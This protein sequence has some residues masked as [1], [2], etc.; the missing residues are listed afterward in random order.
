MSLR[1]SV[2]NIPPNL[3]LDQFEQPFKELN[4]FKQAIYIYNNL[5]QPI[6]GIV[7]FTSLESADY[8]KKIL[9]NFKY[10]NS[11]SGILIDFTREEPTLNPQNIYQPQPI[12]RQ[13]LLQPQQ[14]AIRP[15]MI[16][17]GQPPNPLQQPANVQNS[18]LLVNNNPYMRGPVIPGQNPNNPNLNFSLP[19]QAQR[20][21]PQPL[22]IDSGAMMGLYSNF[23]NPGFAPQQIKESSKK[24]FEI[25]PDATNC[26]YV[27]GVPID[28]SEREVSR[29]KFF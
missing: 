29:M 18:Q 15:Q 1:L 8:A 14:G 11:T 4:G 27:D 7:E 5:N 13:Q 28:S 24:I 2:F 17:T 21:G 23:L 16:Q 3:N 25:P 19:A 9:Q 12:P 20:N 10:P 6:G 26:L 22:Q